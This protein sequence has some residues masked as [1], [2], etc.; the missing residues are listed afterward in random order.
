MSTLA[1]VPSPKASLPE[2]AAA[3]LAECHSPITFS[4][5]SGYLRR[6]LM[7]S[8][9]LPLSKEMVVSYLAHERAAGKSASVRQQAI[10]AIRLLAK[11]SRNRGIISDISLHAIL[12]VKAPRTKGV[13][14]GNWMRLEDVQAL[15]KLPYRK[16]RKGRQ[17]FV[18]LGLMVGC[19]LRRNEV[20]TLPWSCYQEREGRKCL[21][22]LMG[23]GE[24]L[25]TVP[26]PD[27][28]AYHMDLW[29]GGPYFPDTVADLSERQIWNVV[30]YYMTAL[31]KQKGHEHCAKIAPH[32]LRRTMAKLMNKAGVTIEQIAVTLGHCN[33]AT[34]Q[35]Y[36]NSGLEL[37]RGRAA[38]D[39]IKISMEE[40]ND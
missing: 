10:K 28:L 24:K 30:R 34:T 13:R 27:W 12:D 36:L 40:E 20:A 2:V 39:S 6:F 16:T 11:E 22:D 14:S 23:K 31:A 3:A 4:S 26:V 32:D 18:I 5:Y 8:R 9:G 38:V 35:R 17:H 21:V 37:G 19:G 7:F 1:I 25:R 15:L 29:Q 33:I